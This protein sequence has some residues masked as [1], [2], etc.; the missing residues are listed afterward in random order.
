MLKKK[1]YEDAI[2]QIKDQLDWP[3]KINPSIGKKA[4]PMKYK[5]EWVRVGNTTL[6]HLTDKAA[7][8]YIP[9]MEVIQG[10]NKYAA[11]EMNQ[12][13]PGQFWIP[14]SHTNFKESFT[15]NDA[16]QLEEGATGAVTMTRWIAV[17]KGILLDI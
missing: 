4:I 1:K 6:L 16:A 7:L 5:K 8:V 2:K 9:A 3:D 12:L 11:I 15:G 13:P 17:K 14:F 10:K